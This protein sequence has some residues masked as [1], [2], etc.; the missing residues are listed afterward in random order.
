M[1]FPAPWKSAD[2]IHAVSAGGRRD[3]PVF[4]F[5]PRVWHAG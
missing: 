2:A 5:T 1:T 4:D 3:H